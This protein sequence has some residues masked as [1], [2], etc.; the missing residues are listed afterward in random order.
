MSFIGRNIYISPKYFDFFKKKANALQES[1]RFSKNIKRSV[2]SRTC[3][4]RPIFSNSRIRCFIFLILK[5]KVQLKSFAVY[6][7]KY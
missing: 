5:Y 2:F 7:N 3:S 6:T 1:Y 4:K